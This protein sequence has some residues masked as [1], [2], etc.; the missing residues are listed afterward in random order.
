MGGG[1]ALYVCNECI[2]STSVLTLNNVDDAEHV[3]VECTHHSLKLIVGVVY[4]PPNT[5][6]SQFVDQMTAV[7]DQLSHTSSNV[8]IAGDFN[9]DLFQ[10]SFDSNVEH[11]TN[12][13]L[14]YG[15]LPCVSRTTRLGEGDSA[16]LLDNFFCNNLSIINN[17]GIILNDISDHFPVFIDCAFQVND[18]HIR[19][20]QTVTSFN[21]NKIPDLQSYLQ[22]ELSDLC[23]LT[24]AED[25]C[26]LL[27]DSYTSGISRYSDTYIPSRK[28]TPIKPWI[29]P[30][31]LTSINRKN[32]LFRL[33]KKSPTAYNVNQYKRYKNFFT[34]VL[35]NAKKT[36]YQNAL[37][38]SG[39]RET[40]QILNEMTKGNVPQH[41]L[42]HTFKTD[43]NV[44]T[45]A[46]NIAESF[47]TYFANV[48]IKLKE[49]I[50][51][52]DIDPI[53]NIPN[54]IGNTLSHFEDI[55]EF[56]L[57]NIITNANNVGGGIDGINARIFKS[58]FRAILR[59]LVFFFNL[60]LR[61]GMF[62][63]ALKRA[64]IKPIYK[65]GSKDRF[66][67]YRPISILPFLSKILE[68]IVYNRLE[69]Y[70][71]SNETISNCQ[72][73]FRKNMSTYMPI[74]LV[75]DKITE[76]FEA[77]KVVC[78]IYLD[79][80]K[81]FDTVNVN[82]LLQK[83]YMYGIRG[84]T[85]MMIKSY[86]QDRTQC[87]E[88]D[89]SRSSLI[90]IDIGVPQGSILG[91]LLFLIYINDFPLIS[92][93]F[94]AYLY[95]DDTAIFVEG[96]DERQLQARINNIVPRISDW[97][98]AN[99]LSI[100]TDKTFCQLYNNS[101][102]KV[103]VTV[104]LTGNNIRF[105]KTV[106][107]LGMYIDDDLR[108]KSHIAHLTKILSRNVGLISRVRY[109]LT[110]KQLLLLYNALFLPYINYCCMIFSN[111]YSTSITKIQNLQKRVIRL[112]DG[113]ERLAHTAP[114][115]KK[116]K[117]LR[118]TDIGKQQSLLLLHR[119]LNGT[120]PSAL[121]SFFTLTEP[122]RVTRSVHHFNEM[123]TEKLFRTHTIRWA[124]PRLWNQI[125]SPMFPNI[126]TIPSSKRQLKNIIRGSLLDSY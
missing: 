68:K 23:Q 120:L 55:N 89:H 1:V 109:F 10:T 86:L 6:G 92:H 9:F 40:W 38:D 24:N 75:Q 30:A 41:K 107:Y 33:K 59:Q 63:S 104:F 2:N 46:E 70:F 29:T 50:P 16:S 98:A 123:F 36:Y 115:F 57:E 81:A 60:C 56:E 94:N 26:K 61:Q 22:N 53:A 93:N 25:A 110:W 31:I 105:L 111:T 64:V 7:L 79:L 66:S 97:F 37:N 13:F 43:E 71:D 28:K 14:S 100:N 83:L 27:I 106:K 65:T 118:L 69:Y 116:L 42:P 124:G 62:P 11:F 76:A 96:N 121:D 122:D 84:Q 95:A 77:G 48:G 21:Y 125:I 19:M 8:L 101:R 87:V 90:P 17:S 45:G 119:K 67:N 99:Q 73:G 5:R 47:N 78:G 34:Q 91:P 103:T 117:I 126:Q 44:V 49:N 4:R 74:L 54:E 72:F 113:S 52:C 12:M 112:I 15:F 88:I 108:W 80:R 114:I 20:R 82:I 102:N 85:H 32:D 3:F 58:T 35:R 39:P 51:P 18:S